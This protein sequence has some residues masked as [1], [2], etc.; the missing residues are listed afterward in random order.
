MN[1]LIVHDNTGYI[2]SITSGDPNPREPIGVPF[3][4]VDIPEGKQVKITNGVGVDTSVTPNQVILEDIPPNEVDTL[5]QQ[6][7]ELQDA[8]VE[9]ADIVAGGAV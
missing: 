9:I 7:I 8:L 6:V 5:K 4:W 3:L 1:T 2:I